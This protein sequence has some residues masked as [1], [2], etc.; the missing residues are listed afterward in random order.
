MPPCVFI[1]VYV[2]EFGRTHRAG[3][4]TVPYHMKCYFHFPYSFDCITGVYAVIG[5]RSIT[6]C[7]IV[8]LEFVHFL[9]IMRKKQMN[10]SFVICVLSLE[11]VQIQYYYALFFAKNQ[12]DT[13]HSAL[14]LCTHSGET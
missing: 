14:V 10:E 5:T 8:V 6:K 13:F 9:R 7:A 12:I 2:W 11:F 1:R 3:D 4:S